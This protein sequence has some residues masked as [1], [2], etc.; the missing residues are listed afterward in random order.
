MLSRAQNIFH[1]MLNISYT[2]ACAGP[3]LVALK[4][5]YVSSGRSNS[6]NIVLLAMVL[7]NI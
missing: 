7:A 1:H 5:P 6:A 3:F 4:F 2:R